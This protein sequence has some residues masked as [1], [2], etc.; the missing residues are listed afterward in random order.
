MFTAS[1]MSRHCQYLYKVG[2]PWGNP[3]FPP[4]FESA[5]KEATR[6]LPYG[7]SADSWTSPHRTDPVVRLEYLP[8]LGR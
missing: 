7:L 6:M 8:S 5:V 1:S 4:G 3:I 2:Y